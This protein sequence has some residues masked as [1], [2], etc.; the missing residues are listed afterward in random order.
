[1]TFD[2]VRRMAAGFPETV[3]TTSHGMPAIRV[4]K[5]LMCRQRE[6]DGIL[7]VLV[8]PAVKEALMASSPETYFQTPHFEGYAWFLIRLAEIGPDELREMLHDAWSESAT[9]TIRKRYPGM[10]PADGER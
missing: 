7:A 4:G 10:R 6:E 2:D 5:R 1:M 3:E 8:D 9:P